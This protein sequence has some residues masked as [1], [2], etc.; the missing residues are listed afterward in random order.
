MADLEFIETL[1]LMIFTGAI[2]ALLAHKFRIPTIV[3]YLVAGIVLGAFSQSSESVEVISEIGIVLLLFLVGLELN[4]NMIRDLGKEVLK[5]ASGQIVGTV[6]LGAGVCL[7]LGFDGKSTLTVAA[8]LIFSSTVVAVKSLTEKRET[9]AKHGRVAI[10]ILLIQ[11]FLAIVLLT[12]LAGLD[13]NTEFSLQKTLVNLLLV[14]LAVTVI[15]ALSYYASRHLV[16][17]LLTR[18]A[19]YPEMLFIWSLCWCFALVELASFLKLSHEIGAFVAGFSISQMPF[20]HELSRRVSPV[21]HFSIAVFFISLG[22]GLDLALPLQ[23]WIAVAVLSVVILFGK[24][25]IVTFAAVGLRLDK[26]TSCFSGLLL[27]QISEFSLI[28]VALA[29]KKGLIDETTFSIVGLVGLVTISISS[30]GIQ[31]KEKLYLNARR[32]RWLKR[33][34]SLQTASPPPETPALTQHVIVVGMNTLGATIAQKLLD[35][36]ETV[37]AVDTNPYRLAPLN[38]HKL[39]GNAENQTILEEA[40]LRHAK[41]LVS[42]LHIEDTNELLAWRCQRLGIP[43]AIHAVVVEEAADLLELD[44]TYLMIPKVDGIKLQTRKLGKLGFLEP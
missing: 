15:F 6:V 17:R 20:A 10:G 2:F 39:M 7:L 3:G 12:V 19:A 18:A 36:G 44:V 30:W 21:M 24:F 22:V 29:Q 31:H 9:D 27:N 26:R 37:L 13:Q 32:N 28:F 43:C 5:L 41:L 14:V 25:A 35:R 38:C 8:A 4:V 16:Q 42:A 34:A 23:A 1:G 33:F 11:D 40:R